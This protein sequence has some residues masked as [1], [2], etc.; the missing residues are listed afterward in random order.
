M[1]NAEQLALAG[2]EQALATTNEPSTGQLLQ[3][4]ITQGITADNVGALERLIALKE[5]QEERQAEKDF[6]A[7]FVSLQK[8]IPEIVAKSVIPNRGK[9]ERF[10]DLAHVVNPLLVKNGFS[11]SFAMSAADGKITET[12]RLKHIGG[13]SQENSFTVRV[14]RADTE[15]QADTKAAT[16]AKRLALANCLNLVIRQDAMQDED[17]SLVG[18][19]V[20]DEQAQTL[21]EMIKD[22]NSD[23]KKFLA[24]AQANSIEEIGSA[25]YNRCF[26][27]LDAKRRS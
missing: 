14:G 24:F 6:N 17:A 22:T 9:Y 4:V 20:S 21:H 7:A 5:R 19:P 16:T 11:I 1:K 25:D 15:T 18:E 8:E 2:T 23:E 12:C 26:R 27:A 13:H 3:A 10:E